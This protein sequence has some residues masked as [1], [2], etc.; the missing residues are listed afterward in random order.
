LIGFE[1]DSVVIPILSYVTRK[2]E[3]QKGSGKNQG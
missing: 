3:H 1:E 2:D